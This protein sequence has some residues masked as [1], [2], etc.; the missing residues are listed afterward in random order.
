MYKSSCGGEVKS[1]VEVSQGM[2]MRIR[3]GMEVRVNQVSRL[4]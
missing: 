1:G 3:Q 4:G 2:E